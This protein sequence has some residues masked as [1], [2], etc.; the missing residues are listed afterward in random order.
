MKIVC[1]SD[2]HGAHEQIEIPEGDIFIHAGDFTMSGDE[3]DIMRFNHWLGS[4]PH[5]HKIVIAGNHDL[6]FE[7]NPSLAQS[8]I[9]QA[10]YLEDSGIE[11]AGLKFWGSPI[12][13]WFCDWAFNRQRG[14]DI[15]KHWALIPSDIDILITHGPPMG[16]LDQT[17][18]GLAA[19]CKD[20]WE[21]VQDLEPNLHLFGHIHEAYGQKKL[22]RTHFINASIMNL[23][24]EPLHQAVVIEL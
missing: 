19:G 5:P 13:P 3:Q 22:G 12:T 8:F 10:I 11:I 2:T 9:D 1:I 24:Y 15:Q 21:I 6:L 7:S 23:N 4:L 16:I 18:Q 14:E 20:L 17:F